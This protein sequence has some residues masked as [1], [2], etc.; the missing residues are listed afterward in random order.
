VY[1]VAGGGGYND[2][3]AGLVQ[4]DR[5]YGIA[6]Q[7]VETFERLRAHRQRRQAARAVTESAVAA[8]G[9][10]ELDLETPGVAEAD[11]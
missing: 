2:G 10:Q 3:D 9:G 1:G 6:D 7:V 8:M 4:G 11:G 5:G